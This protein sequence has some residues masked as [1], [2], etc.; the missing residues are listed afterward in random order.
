MLKAVTGLAV[1]LLAVKTSRAKV[2]AIAQVAQ[3]EER[4]AEL[5]EEREELAKYRQ[6][7]KERRSLEYTIYDKDLHETRTNLDKV[8][9]HVNLLAGC[10]CILLSANEQIKLL[11][12]FKTGLNCKCLLV[13]LHSTAAYRAFLSVTCVASTA[14]A[15]CRI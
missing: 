6:V 7:D 8:S 9:K 15:P 2:I 3:L 10:T 11:A 1:A 5:D 14:N 12:G 4:L 13:S